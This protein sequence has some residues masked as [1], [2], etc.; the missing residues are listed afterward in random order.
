MISYRWYPE[1]EPE[2]RDE[3]LDL[4][5]TAAGFDD[6]AGFSRIHPA[7]VTAASDGS[8]KV[9]HLPV[10][11]RR[12]LSAREDAPLVI[13]A[14]LHLK[15][16]AEGYGTVQFVVHPDYR[17][18]GVATTLVEEMDLDTAA[19]GGWQGTGAHALRCW[20]YSTHPAA[21][22]LAR[23]FGIRTAGRLWTIFRHLSGPFAH[24][25]EPVAEFGDAAIGAPLALGDPAAREV[26][27]RVLDAS[28][29]PAV[30]RERLLDEIRLGDG[31]V[32]VAEDASGK[33]AGFVWYDPV[34]ST[35]LELRAA[36][37]R[38]LVLTDAVRGAGLGT[39]L[40]TAALGMLRGAGAQIG[41][42]RIDPDN[43]AA[44]RMCRLMWFEQEEEHS[45]FQVGE[46]V[47][48]PGFQR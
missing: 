6:E 48:V 40:L 7:D 36:W 4:V 23:R 22:R 8:G 46:W 2:D 19:E 14:Y 11:A 31:H 42:M 27:D 44:V 29:L 45:C 37:I 38:A 33:P 35:H 39:G 1:L 12:D 20:A 15:V 9:F 10:K 26:I 13:V 21:D 18:R 16:D 24:P 34:L 17:S 47:G 43:A 25:L 30:Q 41:L 3:V 5:A 28:S 32:V